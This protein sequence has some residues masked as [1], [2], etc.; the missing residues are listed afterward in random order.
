[1]IGSIIGA[2][3]G[4]SSANKQAQALNN[5]DAKNKEWYDR[6]YNEDI[7]QRAENQQ[8]IN[9]M[10]DTMLNY[11]RTSAGAAAVGGASASSLANEKAA[12]NNALAQ[13]TG[14]IAAAGAAQKDSIES[15]YMARDAQIS[16]AKLDAEKA[17]AQAIAKAGE[18]LDKTI[19]TVLSGFTPFK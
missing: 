15:T 9:Q 12:M 1:M 19:N 17:K 7:T 4:V 8:A 11:G 6:R 3:A 2:I 16:N 5:E 10:K 18:G 13:T 14:N